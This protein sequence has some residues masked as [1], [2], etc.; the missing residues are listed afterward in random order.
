MNVK[1]NIERKKKYSR[2][3]AF[4]LA[5]VYLLM[6]I[7]LVHWKIFGKTLA[8]LELN[9]VLYT[10]HLGIITAG[11]IFMGVTM[12]G[13]IVFGRFFCS[14]ACHILALQDFSEWI[15]LK[16]KIKP[17]FI[18]SRAYTIVPIVAMIYLFIF[19]QIERIINGQKFLKLHTLNESQGWASFITTDF[20]RN[21][22]SIPITILTFFVCGF[23]VIYFLGTRSFCQ[24][25]CPYGV[26]FSITD[27]FA[28]GKIKLTGNCNQC[29][30]CTA[31][32][33][34]HIIVHK[35]IEQFGKVVNSNCL[36][37]LDCVAVCPND[38]IKFG[39]TKPSFFQSFKKIT[40]HKTHYHFS[41]YEDV[42]LIILTLIFTIIFRGLYDTIP[43]LLAITF[44]VI[45]SYFSILFFRMFSTE[46]VETG[47]YVLK[48]SKKISFSGRVF[49]A[50]ILSIFCFSI[51][52]AYIHYQNY[53]GEL[54]YNKVVKHG[55]ELQ[56]SS[57]S[58]EVK[59]AIRIAQ[60]H[61]EN[62]AK[63]GIYSPLS[64]NRQ[65]AS[66]YLFNKDYK[67]AE[68]YLIKML[69]AKPN[70]NEARLRLAKLFFI[71]KKEKE[72]I[73]ELQI[74]V[75]GMHE[76]E[77]EHDLKIRSDAHLTLGHIEEKNG[78]PSSAMNHYELALKDNP[79]NI[80]AMLALG[81]IYTQS[82]K[83]SQAEKYLLKCNEEMPNYPIVHNNLSIIYIKLKNKKL[84]IHHLTEL[85]KLQPNN[86]QSL[87]NLGMLLA[88]VDQTVEGSNYLL[89]AIS[90]NPNY[91]KAHLGLANIYEKAGQKEESKYH[92]YKVEELKLMVESEPN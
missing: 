73:N 41:L 33:S 66:I 1:A 14:W 48:Q 78:F 12:I 72:A 17:K 20:W 11:F 68:L 77:T 36:K 44:A 88:S 6:G 64:L 23:V 24:K 80:E 67:N 50:I 79:K 39:F 4:A 26:I 15:L 5:S 13:T 37:D 86:P 81:V 58:N 7:H 22:P 61:L 70:D 69:D 55:N 91:M 9:E 30:I 21:L 38:A 42:F 89:R 32:C 49:V 10:I 84:A 56:I 25:I 18:N 62:A 34:S 31:H 35:E 3:R 40:N 16:I 82:G 83:F 92:K 85:V 65:L 47:K 29:G 52:S 71:S 63:Y 43:F 53:K 28:P 75:G 74:I 76:F 8:P 46:Y 87:Y 54:E 57:P 45:F 60:Y 2:W 51:H 19:P 59:K 27:K 90:V